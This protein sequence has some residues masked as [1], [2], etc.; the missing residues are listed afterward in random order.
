VRIFRQ[1]AAAEGLGRG[2]SPLCLS[3][4]PGVANSITELAAGIVDAGYQDYGVILT[5][6]IREIAEIGYRGLTTRGRNQ[7]EAI[8]VAL[9]LYVVAERGALGWEG[10]CE[11]Q[12][13]CGIP[14]TCETRQ[15][16]SNVR[17]TCGL[18][19]ARPWLC[20][21]RDGPARQVNAS[22]RHGTYL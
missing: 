10:E 22:V 20:Q 8:T 17:I 3:N 7:D 9:Y 11:K 16:M 6:G 4:T 12:C 19:L 18:M 14:Y 15:H 13:Q 5:E 1:D 2:D 21:G